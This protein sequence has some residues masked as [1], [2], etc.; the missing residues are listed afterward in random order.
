MY[1]N[2]NGRN[3]RMIGDRTYRISHTG[4]HF[5][6]MSDDSNSATKVYGQFGNEARNVDMEMKSKGTS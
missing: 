4:L 5:T 1:I 6:R 3:E 2:V